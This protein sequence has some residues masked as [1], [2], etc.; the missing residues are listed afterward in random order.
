MLRSFARPL[1]FVL[2]LAVA[3]SVP[4]QSAPSGH[5][6]PNTWVSAPL[7]TFAN[8][9]YVRYEAM[10]DGVTANNRPFRVPC[11]IIAPAQ[12]AQGS[13]LLLFDWLVPSTI[14]TAVGQEQADARYIM[15]DE[16]L[17][18]RG[19]AYAT[20]R[21]QA[22]AIGTSSPDANPTRPWSDGLLDTSSEFI[23]SAGDE[24][25]IVVS[26][27]AAL[28]T[29]PLALQALGEVQRRAA[30][31]YS[32]G[33]YRLR[34]LLRMHQGIGQFDFS[35]VGGTGNGYAHP[36]GNGI[37]F[38]GAEREPLA[39][40]GLEIDFQSETD[41]VV[42]GAHKTRHEEPNY[43]V[44]QFAGVTHLRALDAF[45][46]GLED[47]E[48]AN[49]ADWVAF[50]R[51]L[52][53]AGDKWCDG[54]P[55][56][57]SIWLGAPNDP[58]IARDANGNALVTYVGGLPY[59]GSGYRLPAVAVGENRYIPFDPTYND[60]PFLGWLRA[61]SGSHV[62]LTGSFP[63][64]AAYVAAI[65]LHAL[66]LQGLGYLLQADADAIILQATQSSIGS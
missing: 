39:G 42:L 64:H 11:Q 5:I 23:T 1:T 51:A 34:G 45:E 28:R 53:A 14:P 13:G 9:A 54:I 59:G 12:P 10:F 40:A 6:D 66:G 65:T 46:F 48:T 61:L 8:V 33:G 18:G 43:R 16:F 57:P 35:L 47:P 29:D 15:T 17:F 49:P 37:A 24:F 36:K 41:V 7:G 26:Y 31:S 50:V 58:Q 22:E 38:V 27:L 52:F 63:S 62:D 56:P 4:A 3:C 21:C 30:F 25:D 55:P 20:V 19:L 2:S 32:A 44:Y 60:G